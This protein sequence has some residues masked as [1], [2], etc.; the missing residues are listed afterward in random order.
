MGDGD[1]CTD[2]IA[3]A[4]EAEGLGQLAGEDVKAGIARGDAGR[5]EGGVLHLGGA[6]MGDGI[7]D[8]RETDGRGIAGGGGPVA[9][10][11][12]NEGGQGVPGHGAL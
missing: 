9:E 3:L 10:I 11:V 1:V 8:D 2:E 7:A 5:L 6:G 4:Q 12:K